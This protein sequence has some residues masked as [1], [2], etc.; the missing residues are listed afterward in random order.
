MCIVRCARF[1]I[2][3]LP[4]ATWLL[5]CRLPDSAGWLARLARLARLAFF[6]DWGLALGSCETVVI[7]RLPP[8][9]QVRREY[10]TSTADGASTAPGLYGRLF[11]DN[12]TYILLFK[13]WR[14]AAVLRY[15]VSRVSFTCS[16][17][18]QSVKQSSFFGRPVRVHHTFRS[19]LDQNV[20]LSWF[21]GRLFGVSRA[22][23][24]FLGQSV[25]VSS[26]SGFH[27]RR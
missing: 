3:R 17:L 15:P 7:F 8:T 16:F 12:H 23:R 13:S 21:F 18:D 11:S 5:S 10:G 22:I 27:L 19:F 25:K 24:S 26:F 9:A 4:L 14:S 2:I 20:K 6:P 1:G